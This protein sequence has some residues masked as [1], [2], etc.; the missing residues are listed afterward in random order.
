M[1]EPRRD[2]PR[3]SLAVAPEVPI[4]EVQRRQAAMVGWGAHG[5]FILFF[6]SLLLG[7]V[8]LAI[9]AYMGVR[10]LWFQGGRSYPAI[11]AHFKH[12]S[13]GAELA[14]G[15]PYRILRVLP[16]VF[17]EHF[18]PEGD[19]SHF[20]LLLEAEKDR[21][22]RPKY[23][24][25]EGREVK[26]AT[27]DPKVS[28]HLP[29]GFATGWR[30]GVEVAWFNCAVCHTGVVK[31]PGSDRPRIVPG[32]PAN[33]VELERLFIALLDMAVD[34]RFKLEEFEAR[35]PP[36]ERLNWFERQLWAW[37]VVPNTRATL[38]ERRSQLIALFDP[39]RAGAPRTNADQC[40][41]LLEPKPGC[42][43]SFTRKA[44]GPVVRER[45]KTVTR[46]GPGRVDTFNPY[47]MMNFGIDA[48]CLTAAE[49]T[50]VSDFPSI[51]LQGPR[52][53]RAMHLHW[54]GN[55]ASLKE[56]N[57]SAA[58]GAGVTEATV[59]HAS[60][61]RL[62]RWL[63]SFA[64]PPSP[65]LQ[66]LDPGRVSE[67][68]R[69]YMRECASC[70]GHQGPNGY[71]FEGA[72][73][74]QI[75]PIDYVGTDRGR[76]DS[77][78]IEM[79][80]YQK[81]RLFCGEPEHRFRHFKK[82]DGYANMPLDGLWLRAPYLHNGSV[83]TLADLLEKPAERPLAFRR[84][85]EHVALDPERGGFVAPACI[86]SIAAESTPGSFCF[87]TTLAGNSNRGHEY[88]TE[89]SAAEK[90]ALLGYLLSF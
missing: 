75:E 59:D 56:R 85:R 78:T 51:F 30:A 58:L 31:V 60:L 32:M 39:A 52:G 24:I 84:G 38:I 4:T 23:D 20:G 46:W 45:P 47:K 34:R 13:I 41:P 29:I 82:T 81:D 3:L 71:V 35:H 42:S 50:G 17:P 80:K 7:L 70:H 26:A 25:Y 37:V 64:P 36:E 65:Y 9:A 86:P 88:G 10:M 79:E 72:R 18:A 87:D 67:G 44:P 11:A 5:R 6:V 27:D 28:R 16:E 68:R 77:Y 66:N 43:T 89:L 55:N 2:G 21:T 57:L 61:G 53:A 19:W 62:E 90:H 63:E 49:R 54:D 48:D 15:M 8:L 12:G 74:G 33:T 83:P 76:L 14:S 22:G 69:I 1:S 40:R 73:L